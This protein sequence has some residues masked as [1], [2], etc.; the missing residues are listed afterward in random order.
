MISSRSAGLSVF[1]AGSIYSLK[2]WQP[3][4]FASTG[5]QN[6]RKSAGGIIDLTCQPFSHLNVCAKLNLSFCQNGLS[7]VQGVPYVMIPPLR[8]FSMDFGYLSGS[9]TARPRATSV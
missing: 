1:S 2:D 7:N 8:E 9:E 6:P 5:K 3:L 4:H